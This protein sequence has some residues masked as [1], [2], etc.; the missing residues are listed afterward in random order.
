VRSSTR[1][2]L[3]REDPI[4]EATA[5]VTAETAASV[6]V[7]VET[8]T[9]LLAETTI[10]VVSAEAIAPRAIVLRVH[11]P[12]VPVLLTKKEVTSNVNA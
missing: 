11:A 6:V 9:V 5:E 10:A 8:A 3:A 2:Q 12:R 7:S 1:A 4:A